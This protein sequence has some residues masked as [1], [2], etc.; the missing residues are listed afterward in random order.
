MLSLLPGVQTC[1]LTPWSVKEVELQRPGHK[2]DSGRNI[3]GGGGGISNHTFLKTT[4]GFL[5]IT[6]LI[7]EQINSLAATDPNTPHEGIFQ[8]QEESG[9]VR[10]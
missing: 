7:L 6:A 4:P 5:I 10:D 8:A 9:S 1:S 2:P 3:P